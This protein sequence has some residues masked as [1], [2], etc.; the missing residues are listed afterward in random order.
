MS[1]GEVFGKLGYKEWKNISIYLS[2]YIYILCV[3]CIY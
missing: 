2:I 1:S 3:Y